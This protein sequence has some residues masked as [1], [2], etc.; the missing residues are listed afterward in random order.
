[1]GD[2]HT[3]LGGLLARPGSVHLAV[4]HPGGRLVAV[5]HLMPDDDR[6]EAALLVEDPWQNHG[7]GTTLLRHL[8]GHA[9]HQGWR[10]VYGLVLPGDERI[11]AML[12]RTAIPVQRVE[13]EGVMTVWAD[14]DDIADALPLRRGR[15][16][17]PIRAGDS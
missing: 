10:E 1:M 3:Y 11:L 14:T 13:E 2:P 16:R 9:V 8:G 6:V 17:H 15:H 7:L 5:G 12:R 4:R